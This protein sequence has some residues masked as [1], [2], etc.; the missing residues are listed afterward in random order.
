MGFNFSRRTWL[1]RGARPADGVDAGLLVR[2]RAAR[3]SRGGGRTIGDWLMVDG[4]ADG[5]DAAALS[6]AIFWVEQ[7][8]RLEVGRVIVLVY[9]VRIVLFC[10]TVGLRRDR[11]C[12]RLGGA[13]LRRG[14]RGGA[15]ADRW[16]L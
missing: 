14:S 12:V 3:D 1:L 4:R 8:R 11:R 16:W 7:L 10:I 6:C 9:L 13:L 15:I 5:G 2:D